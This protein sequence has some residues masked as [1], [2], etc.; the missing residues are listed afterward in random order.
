M[1]DPVARDRPR[2]EAGKRLLT[3]YE[4]AEPPGACPVCGGDCTADVGDIDET[5]DPG[6]A[7]QAGE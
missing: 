3:A 2:T 5:D 4:A 6:Y 7:P 1:T